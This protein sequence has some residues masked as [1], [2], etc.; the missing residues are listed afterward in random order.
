ML[1]DVCGFRVKNSDE[2]AMAL[3]AKTKVGDSSIKF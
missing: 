2:S 3:H 1:S